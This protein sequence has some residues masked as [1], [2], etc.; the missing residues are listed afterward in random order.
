MKR[1]DGQMFLVVGRAWWAGKEMG[2]PG[3]FIFW[4]RLHKRG[5]CLRPNMVRTGSL[6]RVVA[7]FGR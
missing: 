2:G 5:S 6:K 1:T 7:G 3:A 4:T